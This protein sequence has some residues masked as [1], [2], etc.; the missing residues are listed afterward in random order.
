[1]SS[2]RP[3]PARP[4]EGRPPCANCGAALRLHNHPTAYGPEFRILVDTGRASE[5]TCPEAY[6]PATLEAA[7][8]ELR[9]AERSG[10]ETRIFVAR[11]NLQRLDKLMH[12]DYGSIEG[13]EPPRANWPVDH[14]AG[15]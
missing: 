11:G 1:M 7:Q 15:E 5:L 3:A 6:R 13:V 14:E 4:G 10:D 12:R 2:Y 9:A 8:S